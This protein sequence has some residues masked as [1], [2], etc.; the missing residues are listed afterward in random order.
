MLFLL[1]FLLLLLL[2]KALPTKIL[3]HNFTLQTTIGLHGPHKS[4]SIQHALLKNP[5]FV[6]TSNH[7]IASVLTYAIITGM[8]P[9]HTTNKQRWHRT[10]IF[11][12]FNHDTQMDSIQ[13][14]RF[15]ITLANGIAIISPTNIDR[16]IQTIIRRELLPVSFDHI[17]NPLH[18]EHRFIKELYAH[19]KNV[20]N[21]DSTIKC[22]LSEGYF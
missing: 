8:V 22:I 6:F 14:Y 15:G 5:A 21:F 20:Q 9:I 7:S 19:V 17:C 11:G 3:Y 10:N 4:S 12:A 2:P 13:L 16:H 18:V 1:L